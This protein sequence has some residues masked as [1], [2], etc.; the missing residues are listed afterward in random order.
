MLEVLVHASFAHGFEAL[1]DSCFRTPNLATPFLPDTGV[2][3]YNAVLSYHQLVESAGGGYPLDNTAP[4]DNCVRTLDL[5]TPICG[6][7]SYLVSAAM[8]GVTTCLH[9]PGQ[10]SWQ[11][12][13]SPSHG[14]TSSCR[15][16]AAHLTWLAAVPCLD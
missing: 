11:R 15:V 3:L 6:N 1:Y 4:F 13:S 2:E 10:L 8:S 12:N 5:T 7:L 9:F 14:C 16:C